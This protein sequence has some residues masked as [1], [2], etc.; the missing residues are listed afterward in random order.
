MIQIEV[1]YDNSKEFIYLS[2]IGHADSAPQGHDLVCAAT[3]GIILGGI[4]NL[5]EKFNLKL[6]EEKGLLELSRIGE[7]S[8]HDKIVLETIIKQL[9]SVARDN[10]MYVK[11]SVLTDIERNLNDV[12]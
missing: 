7:V 11:I 9:Q 12:C 10:P 2:M 6:D 3:S 4:N 1:R 8:S 5:Q